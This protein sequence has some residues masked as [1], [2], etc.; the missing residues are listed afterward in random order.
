MVNSEFHYCPFFLE[1]FDYIEKQ[2]II[3]Y[4]KL[5]P[6]LTTRFFVWFGRRLCR[7][8]NHT[9]KAQTCRSIGA[10]LPL[11]K[12]LYT[13]IIIYSKNVLDSFFMKVLQILY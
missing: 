10:N 6:A 2:Y 9:K 8:P 1:L 5:F 3:F 12:H 7:R 13:I 4:W 11:R